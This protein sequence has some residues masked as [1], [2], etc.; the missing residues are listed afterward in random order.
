MRR[1]PAV[2]C[3]TFMSDGLEFRPHVGETFEHEFKIRARDADDLY[4]IEGG[5]G[6]GSRASA[7]QRNLAEITAA[8]EVREDQFAAWTLFRHLHESNAHQIETVCGVALAADDLS[9]T[10]P[11]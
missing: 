4:V 7:E 11:D 9:G 1:A 6:G 8:R 5:A 3:D 10:E 2:F